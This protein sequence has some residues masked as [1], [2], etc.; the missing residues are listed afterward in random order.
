MYYETFGL[1]EPPF[2]LT[3]DSRYLFLSKVHKRAKAYMDYAVWKRDGFIVLTGEIGAGKTTLINKLLSEIGEDV[4]IV[5]IFQT[6]LNEIE[7]LQAMLFELGVSNSEIHGQGKVELLHRLNHFLIDTYS[8]GRHVVLIVDEGQN[9]STK[10]LEEI[11]MLSGLELDK[12]KLLNIILVGQPEM[13][14]I[15]DQ[16]NMAQLVQRIRLRFHLGPLKAEETIEFIKHRLKI[17]GAKKPEKIFK[18]DTFTTIQEAT[19]GIPRKLNVLCDTALV[20]AF[21]DNKT[22]VDMEAI[23]DALSEL[24]W[25][26]YGDAKKDKAYI[27]HQIAPSQAYVQKIPLTS[28]QNGSGVQFTAD[29]QQWK[30]MF[31]SMLKIMGDVTNRMHAIDKKLEKMEDK[32]E[33]IKESNPTNKIAQLS[34]KRNKNRQGDS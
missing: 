21:A 4:E 7:F 15:L 13:N 25:D 17:A 3:P 30:D 6:Q 27:E 24:Q 19:G 33:Q 8:K 11:R 20:C 10:V 14:H 34:A 18:E 5:R 31:S 23:Q 28:S 29:N 32:L 16:P 12:E 22:T 2:Q 9:L 1:T 26:K